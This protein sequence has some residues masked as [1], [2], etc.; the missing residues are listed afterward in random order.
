MIVVDTQQKLAAVC[1]FMFVLGMLFGKL[2][3]P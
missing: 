3:I 1:T 2:V